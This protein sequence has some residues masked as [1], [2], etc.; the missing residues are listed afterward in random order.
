M[1]GPFEIIPSVRQAKILPFALSCP[2]RYVLI[3]GLDVSVLKAS[4]EEIHA[5]RKIA[6]VNPS[7][8][9]GLASDATG[10]RLLRQ[11]FG[12]DM[13]ASS[14]LQQ[15]QQARREGLMCIQ[16][17]FL[18]DSYA[19]DSALAALRNSKV[20]A[21]EILPGHM[22]VKF[23]ASLKTKGVP[24]LA[25]GFI[26]SRKEVQ[27]ILAAGYTGLTTSQRDLWNYECPVA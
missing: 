17:L 26:K 27:E 10:L 6:I 2:S 13:I 20:D 5:A 24:M 15:L 8:V 16:R 11:H 3:S 4:V 12:V 1:T 19:W 14:S 18:V 25:G 22:S 21:V 7:L 9:G 23:A